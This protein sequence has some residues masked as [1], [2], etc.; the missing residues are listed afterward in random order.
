MPPGRTSR[1]KEMKR[2]IPEQFS[3][4]QLTGKIWIELVQNLR[5]L[6]WWP[7]NSQSYL[8]MTSN[9]F[10]FLFTF[11][12]YSS[13][14]V[15]LRFSSLRSWRDSCGRATAEPGPYSLAGIVRER[16]GERR[17]RSSHG[18]ATRVHGFATPKQKHSHAKS[19]Q[20]GSGHGV[21]PKNLDRSSQRFAIGTAVNFL[22]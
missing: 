19:R 6:P 1:L 12:I 4:R 5:I 10:L 17:T 3:G 20:L 7:L 2:L 22:K 9:N 21:S 18:F 14:R 8:R 13:K 15:R 11:I 16:F